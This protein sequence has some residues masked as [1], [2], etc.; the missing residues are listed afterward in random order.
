VARGQLQ[1]QKVM[2]KVDDHHSGVYPR[3]A[4]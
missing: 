1:R 2:L 3:P 4:R